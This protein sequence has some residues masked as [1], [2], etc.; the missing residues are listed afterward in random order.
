VSPEKGNYPRIKPKHQHIELKKSSKPGKAV[1]E[2]QGELEKTIGRPN[3][4]QI[5]PKFNSLLRGIEG[6]PVNL[7]APLV[8]SRDKAQEQITP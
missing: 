4:H 2:Q 5:R 8:E 7:V 1:L 3:R 6:S